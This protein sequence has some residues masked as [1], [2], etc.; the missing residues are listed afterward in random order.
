MPVTARL[1]LPVTATSAASHCFS[2]GHQS[3]SVTSLQ[4][5]HSTEERLPFFIGQPFGPVRF[6]RARLPNSNSKYLFLDVVVG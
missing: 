2:R 4:V 3:A 6:S 5:E 1:F